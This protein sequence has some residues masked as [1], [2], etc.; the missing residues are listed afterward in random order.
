MPNNK[1]PILKNAPITEAL[2]DIRCELPK[3]FNLE[4]F[5]A[6]GKKISEDYPV[7]KQIHFHEAKINLHGSAGDI[8]TLDRMNGYR[9][10]STDGIRIVQLRGDGFT[11]NRLKPYKDWPEL[12]DESVRLWELYKDIAK[13]ERINRIALRYINNLNAPLPMKDFNEYLMCPP[14]VPKGIPQIIA[15]FF[16]RVTVPHKDKKIRANITQSLEPMVELKHKVPIILDIDV[17]KSTPDGFLDE[18]IL[19]ILEKL[20]NFKNDIFF[21][22]ITPK[23]LEIY[24]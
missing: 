21:T 14:E 9:Y 3:D 18:D 22:S 17:Y 1:N 2:V 5:K 20:R 19:A 16:Y 24:L 11:F 23:L 6:I 15:S 7:E 13:P 8:A 12:R 10:E 4:Q